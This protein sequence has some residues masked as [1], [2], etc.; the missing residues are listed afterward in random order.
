MKV[1]RLAVVCFVACALLTSVRAQSPPLSSLTVT[2]LGTGT[3]NPRIDR[4]GPSTLIE[5]GGRRLIFDVG[6]ATTIRLAQAGVAAGTLSA[7]FLTHLHSDH[8]VGLPDLWLSGWLP[9]L[10]ARSMPMR[11]IGPRGTRAMMSGL[12]VAYAE[13]IRMRTTEERLPRRG[14]EVESREFDAD[15]VVFDEGGVQVTAFAVDH[16]GALKPAFGYRV[17]YAGRSVVISGDTRYSENLIRHASGADVLL[18]EVFSAPP[19]LRDDPSVQFRSAHH[20]S[21][22]DAARVFDRVKPRLAVFTHVGLAPDRQGRPPSLDAMLK[23]V[24]DVFKGRV[25][26]GDDLMRIVVGDTIDIA[27]R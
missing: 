25:E 7:V 4:M 16:G 18:H 21:A 15:G 8:T 17:N 6:R 26:V 2:L 12:A 14:T 9:G 5:A 27:R 10:G 3:P 19:E 20:S 24:S 23:E 1:Q 11:L 22:A 13:D